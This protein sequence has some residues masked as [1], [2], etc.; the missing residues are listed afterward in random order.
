MS[1]ITLLV[2]AS[3]CTACRGCQI[4]CK[5]WWDLSATKTTQTGTYENPRDLESNTWSRITFHEYESGGKF[6]WLFLQSSCL[7]CTNAACVDVC[8]TGALKQ[9]ATGFVSFERDLCNGCAYCAE[10]CPFGI[11]RMETINALTG[12]AKASK[13]N[14]CQDRVT[15]GMTPAC[16]KTCPPGALQFGERTAMITKAKERVETLKARGYP[17]ARVYGENEL[18]GLRRMY[19]LT[20]PASA[21]GLPDSPQYPVLASAWQ[22]VI[23]PFGYV[24]TALAVVGLALNWV[25]TRRSRLNHVESL[26]APAPEAPAEKEEV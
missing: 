19:V 17:E 18:G 22:N 21:Y 3:K 24:A 11:P 8:P 5:Q 7:H 15:N 12:E 2:D 25:A 9:N 16:V 10:A 26:A 14:M 6:Q 1:Q 4:A 13:C 20:A 23:Q